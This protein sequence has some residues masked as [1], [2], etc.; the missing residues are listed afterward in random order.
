[1]NAIHHAL[2]TA[3]ILIPLT[4]ILW[5]LITRRILTKV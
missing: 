5:N 4:R 1:M 3:S 2:T